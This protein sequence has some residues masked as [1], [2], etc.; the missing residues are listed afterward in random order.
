MLDPL[1]FLILSF[2]HDLEVKCN[3]LSGDDFPRVEAL[4]FLERYQILRKPMHLTGPV[5]KSHRNLSSDP[6]FATHQL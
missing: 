4:A 1:H 3:R 5:M 2:L 6:G